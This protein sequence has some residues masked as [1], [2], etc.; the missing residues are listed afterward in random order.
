MRQPPPD[1]SS[2]ID[3]GVDRLHPGTVADPDGHG[4]DDVSER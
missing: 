3:T 4:I 2:W 1:A